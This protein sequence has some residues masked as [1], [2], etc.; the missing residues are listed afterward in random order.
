MTDFNTVS[1][2][3]GKTQLP[4]SLG[5]AGG[6]RGSGWDSWVHKLATDPLCFL[7]LSKVQSIQRDPLSANITTVLVAAKLWVLGTEDSL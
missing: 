6:G 1:A 4:F 3:K 5:G 2:D 7:C